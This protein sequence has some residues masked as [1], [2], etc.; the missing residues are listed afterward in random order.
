MIKIKIEIH[1][2]E[3][4]ELMKTIMNDYIEVMEE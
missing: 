2:E 4:W 3:D 1:D